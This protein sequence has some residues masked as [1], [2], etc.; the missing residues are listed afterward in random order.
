TG[1][2]GLVPGLVPVQGTPLPPSFSALYY[3][4]AGGGTFVRADVTYLRQDFSLMLRVPDAAAYRWPEMQRYDFLVRTRPATEIEI[5]RFQAGQASP[6]LSEHHQAVLFAL[7]RLTGHD[8]P[9]TAAEW[10]ATL[11]PAG[12]RWQSPGLK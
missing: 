5:H 7:R 2:T 9:L 10:R 11:G 1:S 3:A 6:A 12:E 8:A 4:G